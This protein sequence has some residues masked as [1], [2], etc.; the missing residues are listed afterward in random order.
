M[1]CQRSACSLEN[2]QLIRRNALPWRQSRQ[3]G[4]VKNQQS[5]HG[6]RKLHRFFAPWKQTNTRRLGGGFKYVL[7]SS[8]FGEMIPIWRAYVSNG[9]VQPPTRIDSLKNKYVVWKQLR[10]FNEI[11]LELTMCSRNNVGV[12]QDAVVMVRFEYEQIEL[13]VSMK[14]YY[15]CISKGHNVIRGF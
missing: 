13:D 10:E 12:P 9:L 5:R 2:S 15:Q 4:F 1:F 7:C 3:S 6:R 14:L 11:Q 8:L